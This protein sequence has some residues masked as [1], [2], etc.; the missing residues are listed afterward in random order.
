[1]K[2]LLYITLTKLNTY[3]VRPFKSDRCHFCTFQGKVKGNVYNTA[4]GD[5]DRKISLK[6]WS[7]FHIVCVIDCKARPFDSSE[8]NQK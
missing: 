2:F 6:L 5:I 8:G 7:S 4:D 1:M 3:T